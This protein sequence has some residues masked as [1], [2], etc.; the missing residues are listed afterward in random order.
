M[1]PLIS[2]AEA[3]ERQRRL[4]SVANRE[5]M[6][7]QARMDPT[8]GRHHRSRLRDVFRL[9]RRRFGRARPRLAPKAVLDTL[10]PRGKPTAVQ[11]GT[12]TQE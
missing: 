3:R 2:E 10:A 7:R 1:H 9:G 6:L 8:A 4:R 11:L 12:D 5:R